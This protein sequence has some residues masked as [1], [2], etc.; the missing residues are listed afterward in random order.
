MSLVSPDPDGLYNGGRKYGKMTVD[1]LTGQGWSRFPF[2]GKQPLRPWP[3]PMENC[4]F[5][6][7]FSGVAG[8]GMGL[9]FGIFMGSMDSA[10]T[11]DPKLADM[12]TKEQL[13]ATWRHTAS[14]GISMGKN[15]AAFG[16]VFGA[17]ECKLE[18]VQHSCGTSCS[19]YQL[20]TRAKKD[21][22]GSTLAGC[23]TGGLLGARGALLP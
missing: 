20:Q 18:K 9:L 11:I 6:S 2:L 8:G 23:V 1:Q 4:L 17:V 12:S 15:F 7:A 5:K 10:A 13:K 19:E 16:L 21:L 22:P 14:R 3:D